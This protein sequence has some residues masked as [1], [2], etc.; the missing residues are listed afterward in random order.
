MWNLA[1]SGL[2][3]KL[4]IKLFVQHKDKAYIKDALILCTIIIFLCGDFKSKYVQGIGA[5]K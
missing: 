1:E 3:R 4:I 2:L 5:L